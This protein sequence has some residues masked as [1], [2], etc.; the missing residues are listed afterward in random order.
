V[1]VVG[2]GEN[3]RLVD[4]VDTEALQDLRLDEVAD[5]CLCHHR[6]RD[7]LDD[8][9]DHV[10]VAHPGDTALRADVRRHPL[11]RHHRDSA[12]VLGDL[13]LLRGDHVHDHTALEHLG[14]AA[15]HAGCAG[16]GRLGG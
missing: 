9:V 8:G 2:G 7:R 15:L 1:N 16:P 5:P 13:G 3:L 10:W 12:C 4:V 11:E 6:D 14:H